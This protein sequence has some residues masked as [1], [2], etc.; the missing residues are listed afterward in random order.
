MSG[1]EFHQMRVEDWPARDQS[2]WTRA[3][4][5]DDPFEAGGLA[6]G[7]RPTTI[8]NIE[9]SWG[10]YLTW[11]HL[12]GSLDE[13]ATPSER[14]VG[15]RLHRFLRAYS[16]PNAASSVA[17]MVRALGDFARACCPGADLTELREFFI[18]FRRKARHLKPPAERFRP[19]SEL[20]KIG[21]DHI[22]KGL[23]I[24][25]STPVTGAIAFRT[26]L[27]FLME[28][29]LPLR[30]SNLATLQIGKTLKKVD[31]CWTV[32]FPGS[33]MKNHHPFEG[34]YP[35]SLTEIIDLWI[36]EVRPLLRHRRT[37]PDLGWMWPSC[38]GEPISQQGIFVTVRE[39]NRESSGIPIATHAFRHSVT[40]QIAVSDPKHI[41]IVTPLLGHAG[42]ACDAVYDLAGSFEAQDAWLEM[43]D[44]KRAEDR[45]V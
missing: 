27:I 38:R 13:G 43:L 39:A 12:D 23:S 9:K 11:L 25:D 19:T 37:M 33:A 20:M 28:V 16:G 5:A 7:W 24:I 17:T 15:D 34:W 18:L 22:E 30:V 42:P 1:S 4:T 21:H 2:L 14:V 32:E 35:A 40:T 8:G 41:G 44:R 29:A 31:D 36:D 45:E 3:R 10:I 6:A 26:G